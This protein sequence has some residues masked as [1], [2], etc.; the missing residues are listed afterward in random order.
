MTEPN[1]SSALLTAVTNRANVIAA[2]GIIGLSAA[3]LT[4]IPLVIW[5]FG[6]AAYLAYSVH[7]FRMEHIIV[8][9]RGVPKEK[10]VAEA[11][12]QPAPVRS[13]G[14]QRI[15]K[16]KSVELEVLHPS[17]SNGLPG[18]NPAQ[19]EDTLVVQSLP[20]ISLLAVHGKEARERYDRMERSF[21]S[22]ENQVS[23]NAPKTKE[24]L[25]KLE[26]LLGKFL[27]FALK[28]QELTDTV[29]AYA[30][31]AKHIR[32]HLAKDG[33]LESGLRAP[34]LMLSAGH[35][36]IPDLAHAIKQAHEYYDRELGEISWNSNVEEPA[37]RREL[38]NRKTALTERKRG[39]DKATK[40]VTNM[41]YAMQLLAKKFEQIETNLQLSSPQDIIAEVDGLINQT[42]II[43]RSI[44]EFEAV[45][46]LETEVCVIG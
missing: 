31:E 11:K 37:L 43:S 41:R 27:F 12:P 7:L 15:P 6:E 18:A 25:D 35:A 1:I 21:H 38:E 14:L 46:D 3:L 13:L 9:V 29:C 19:R 16:V 30:Q 40:L 20:N 23:R 24:L 33:T 45:V 32:H 17:I 42:D 39:L 4:P 10:K 8:E 22:I 5:I 44:E 2:A 26:L 28:E 36:A 34:K